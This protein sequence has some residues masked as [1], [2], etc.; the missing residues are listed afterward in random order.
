MPTITFQYTKIAASGDPVPGGP[1]TFTSFQGLPVID[2]GN[3][4]FVANK[5][6]GGRTIY[7]DSGGAR[8][9]LIDTSTPIP[10]G[11][12]NFSDLANLSLD[13]HELAFL[14]RGSTLPIGG[15]QVMQSCV[16]TIIGGSLNVVADINTTVPGGTGKFRDVAPFCLVDGRVVFSGGDEAGKS[17]LYSHGEAG[18]LTVTDQSMHIPGGPGNFRG[19]SVASFDGYNV[20][21]AQ[22]GPGQHNGIYLRYGGSL[23]VLADVATPIPG[24]SGTFERFGDPHG[25]KGSDTAFNAFGPAGQNGVYRL[26]SGQVVVVADTHTPIPKGQGDFYAFALNA[27]G[28][29]G[30]GT[31]FVGMDQVAATRNPQNPTAPLGQ[32]G[33]Y[34]D[35][36]VGSLPLAGL[37]KVIDLNDT[38]DGKQLVDLACG[39]QGISRRSVVFSATFKDGSRGLYLARSR[40]TWP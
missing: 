2:G 8:T 14:G 38:L 6:S 25:L 30:R 34:T 36:R 39:R 11:V 23:R 21:F 16:C 20:I 37:R 19:F 27:V 17:G 15:A 24:G 26:R 9:A 22:D 13:E 18:I 10:G 33:I 31:V 28:F 35:M 40:L 3:I 1:G 7:L 32:K 12:G 5:S 29:D 4:A